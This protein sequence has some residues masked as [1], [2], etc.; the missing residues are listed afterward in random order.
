[1]NL[2]KKINKSLEKKWGVRFKPTHP[3]K[4]NYDGVVICNKDDFIVLRQEED[5]E[6]DGVVI[7]PKKFIKNIRD[8]KYE[9]CC[10]EILRQNGQLEK[11]TVPDW[12]FECENL[13]QVLSS[14]KN[15]DIWAAVETVSSKNSAFYIGPITKVGRK[16][17]NLY[18]YNAAGK[19]E[20]EYTLPINEIFKIEFDNKY[21]NHFNDYM[22]SKAEEVTEKINF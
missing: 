16:K 2:E 14:L 10:N 13:N 11:I 18:C 1:M 22:Q 21:C 12:I 6:F 17:F 9:K 8:G 19:W 15:L 3:D 5:F 4:D 7:I 20:S